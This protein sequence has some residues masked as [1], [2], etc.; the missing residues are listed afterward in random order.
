MLFSPDTAVDGSEEE[1]ICKDPMV[2]VAMMASV[3]T[4]VWLL[5]G[6]GGGDKTTHMEHC[7]MLAAWRS[8]E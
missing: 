2:R 3:S 1:S 4:K 8:P 6:L 7:S 5:D